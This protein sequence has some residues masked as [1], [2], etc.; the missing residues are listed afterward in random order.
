MTR[1]QF[2]AQ[3]IALRKSG[4]IL[5]PAHLTNYSPVPVT[6]AWGL[7]N[8]SLWESHHTGEDHACAAGSLVSPTC[9]GTVLAAGWGGPGYSPSWG[10]DYGNLIIIRTKSGL[11]DVGFAHLSEIDVKVGDKVVPGQVIG[12][13]GATGNVTG[14]HLHYEVRPAGGLYGSDVSPLHVEHRA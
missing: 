7:V 6:T 10:G 2:I 5:T 13:V 4:H 14:A 8:H 12:L 9:W 1:A 11:W 3:Q